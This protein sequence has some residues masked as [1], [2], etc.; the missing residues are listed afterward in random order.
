MNP[1]TLIKSEQP[2]DRDGQIVNSFE[3]GSYNKDLQKG[4]SPLPDHGKLTNYH[5]DAEGEMVKDNGN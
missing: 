3:L 2:I 4:E 5:Q 1:P